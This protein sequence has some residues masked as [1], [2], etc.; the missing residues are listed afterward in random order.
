MTFTLDRENICFFDTEFVN[1]V[2]DGMSIVIPVS[3]GL[4][5]IDEDNKLRGAYVVMPDE[6]LERARDYADEWV[7]KNILNNPTLK[8]PIAGVS[9]TQPSDVAGVTQTILD[10]IPE[11]TVMAT[12]V[13]TYDMVALDALWGGMIKRPKEKL[14]AYTCLDFASLV[15]IAGYDVLDDVGVPNRMKH[16]A[17]ADALQLAESWLVLEKSHADNAALRA[18]MTTRPR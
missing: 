2:R 5:F 18:A 1:A 16:H 3:F 15:R 8:Q 14:S 11:N 4:V 17:L 12:Y 7:L 9:V 6:V 13:G 10:A